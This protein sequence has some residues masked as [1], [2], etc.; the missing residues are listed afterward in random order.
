[1]NASLN[2]F[3]VRPLSDVFRAASITKLT[4][5][6]AALKEKRKMD[7]MKRRDLEAERARLQGEVD[8]LRAQ[9]DRSDAKAL[10]EHSKA[11]K[12]AAALK[13]VELSV[14]CQATKVRPSMFVHMFFMCMYRCIGMYR[15]GD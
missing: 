7:K 6:K 13:K 3:I 5:K 2:R 11:M 10:S 4:Q 9:V 8:H 15:S 1:M 12:A 14:D